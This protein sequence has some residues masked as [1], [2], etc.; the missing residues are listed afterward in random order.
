MRTVV[1]PFGR[2]HL[3]AASE[4]FAA[5]H[6]GDRGRWPYLPAEYEMGSQVCLALADLLEQEGSRGVAALRGGVVV[7]YVLGKAM[8]PATASPAASVWRPRSAAVAYHGHAAH[9]GGAYDI[10]REMYAALTEQWL[11]QGLFAHYASVNS[12]DAAT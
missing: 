5:R 4:V 6:A 11:S 3:E 2:E 1:E 8:F 9:A 12:C 10:Y 7:G